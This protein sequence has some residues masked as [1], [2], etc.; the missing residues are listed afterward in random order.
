[1]RVVCLLLLAVFACKGKAPAPVPV[2]TKI[3]LRYHP[4]SGAVY[5]YVLE[6]S[7]RFAPDTAA[8]TDSAT[9]TSMTLMFQQ[10]I[11][12]RGA[13]GAL[14]TMTLDSSNVAS[15]MLSPEAAAA[16]AGELRGLSVTGVL[17]DRLRFVRADFSSLGRLPIIVREQVELGIRAAAL[18]FPEEAVGP[19]DGWSIQTELPFAQLASGSPLDVTSKITV[20][21]ITVTR[22][23][24]TVELGVET[25]LPERPLEFNFG[26]QTVAVRLRG[27]ITGNQVF[28]L[29][30]GAVV[31]GMLGG[32]MHLT[33]TGGFFGSQGMMMRVE[34]RAATRLVE[35]P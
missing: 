21:S 22:G 1:M 16:A 25:A 14:V 18:S 26:G 29:T 8:A 3:A 23:D 31:N 28:S 5:R 30:R 13:E 9:L 15:P 6:Q 2:T 32:L 20:R 4:P 34:Q 27:G 24:T 33:V 12:N 17:D 7:S 35:T 10:R 11:G 19:G